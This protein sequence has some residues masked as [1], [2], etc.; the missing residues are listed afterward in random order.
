[1]G[2]CWSGGFWTGRLLRCDKADGENAAFLAR[3]HRSR[4]KIATDVVG[5]TESLAVVDTN[6]DRR[7][8]LSS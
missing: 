6:R 7:G 2:G 5:V 8:I 4:L 1:M 3:A